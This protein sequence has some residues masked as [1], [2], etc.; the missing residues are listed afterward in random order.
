MLQGKNI[1]LGV[2]GSIAVYKALDLASKLT[3]GGARVDVIMTQAALEFVTPL[4]FRSITHRPVVTAMFDL[5]SG[6]SVEHVALAQKADVVIVAPATANTIAKLAMGI[7]DEMLTSTV[8]ATRAPVI[9]APAMDAGM[10]ENLATQENLSKLRSRGF[11][12]V[13]PGYGYLA[14]G[15]MGRGR[16]ADTE[17][18]MGNVRL[19]LG[20]GG[21]LAGKKLVVSAGGTQEPID[22]VRHIGNRSSGKMGYAIAEAARDRGAD[23]VLVSGPTSLPQPVGIEVIPVR[24]TLEMRDAIVKEVA[25]AHAL[26]MAAAVADYQPREFS[27]NKIKKETATL[28]LELIRTPDI[29]SSIRG[30][31][32]RVGFAAE[33]GD[34]VE[35]AREKLKAKDLDLIVANDITASDSGFAVDTNQVILLD[36]EGKVESLPLLPKTEVAHRVLDRLAEYFRKKA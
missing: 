16:L 14:S 6:F 10:Y 12:I 35:N 21:D 11:T 27:P 32:I 29:L 1:V 15:Q 9:V 2:T 5:A 28:H 24:T 26:I 33:S 20:R 34:P 4:S 25:G 23:V 8:L 36:R 13:E 17:E 30:D 3:Q 19:L 22:P 7:A 31:L 18:I